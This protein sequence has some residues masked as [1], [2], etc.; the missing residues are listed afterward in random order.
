MAFYTI[1]SDSNVLLNVRLIIH[2]P[3]PQDADGNPVMIGNSCKGVSIYHDYN[4]DAE[5][6]LILWRDIVK[7]S[8]KKHKF[9]VKYHPPEVSVCEAL[10]M[11]RRV[12]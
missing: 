5:S 11:R 1:I 3:P 2:P 6:Q 7:I 10:Y 9:R 8:Y 12:Q 4:N